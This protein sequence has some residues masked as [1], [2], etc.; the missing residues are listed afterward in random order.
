MRIF[1]DEAVEEG[2]GKLLLLPVIFLRFTWR[3][4]WKNG[5]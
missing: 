4:V 1:I 5:L 3:A 2:F